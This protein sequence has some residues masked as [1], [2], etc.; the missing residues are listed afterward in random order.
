VG[1]RSDGSAVVAVPAGEGDRMVADGGGVSK[2][3]KGCTVGSRVRAVGLCDDK[4][5]KGLVVGGKERTADSAFG[6]CVGT[7]VDGRATGTGVT[8]ETEPAGLAVVGEN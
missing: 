2:G 1:D 4:A 6:D 8:G 3:G 5:D 7:E